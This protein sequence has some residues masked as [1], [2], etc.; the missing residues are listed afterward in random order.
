MPW[1]EFGKHNMHYGRLLSDPVMRR[2]QRKW[3][4]SEIHIDL[5]WNLGPRGPLTTRAVRVELPLQL[6]KIRT[7]LHQRL[8]PRRAIGD[9]HEP[10]SCTSNSPCCQCLYSG[11]NWCESFSILLL[12]LF[13]YFSLCSKIL[14]HLC[15]IQMQ[16][17][18]FNAVMPVTLD[19]LKVDYIIS[20]QLPMWQ[21][22]WQIWGAAAPSPWHWEQVAWTSKNLPNFT[23]L[24]L[25]KTKNSYWDGFGLKQLG[26]E[27]CWSGIERVLKNQISFEIWW[28][29][30]EQDGGPSQNVPHSPLKNLGSAPVHAFTGQWSILSSHTITLLKTT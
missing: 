25:M 2:N 15:Q 11:I 28:R 9:P 18:N 14:V 13:F 30:L 27:A 21:A 8:T 26:I 7:Y 10:K 17:Q 24:F 1:L 4:C 29:P 3:F 22:H 5:C 16:H 19:M 23:Y 6:K 12:C 20:N